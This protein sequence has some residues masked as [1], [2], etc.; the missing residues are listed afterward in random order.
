MSNP[1]KLR[2]FFNQSAVNLD[3]IIYNWYTL[4]IIFLSLIYA[5]Y[6]HEYMSYVL[7]TFFQTLVH[8]AFPLKS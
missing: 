6:V 5:L 8:V 4:F 1:K 2:S 3:F 7:T